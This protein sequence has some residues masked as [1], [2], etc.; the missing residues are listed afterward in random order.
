MGYVLTFFTRAVTPTQ[1]FYKTKK[2]AQKAMSEDIKEAAKDYK[3]TGYVKKGSISGGRVSFDHPYYGTD[4][5]V[6]LEAQ[7][8]DQPHKTA[9]SNRRGLVGYTVQCLKRPVRLVTGFR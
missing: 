7:Q 3:G 1:E 6:R 5:Q 4:Y 8:C 9:L 2:E